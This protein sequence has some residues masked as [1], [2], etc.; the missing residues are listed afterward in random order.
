MQ[1]CETLGI[2]STRELLARTTATELMQWEAYKSLEAEE[3]LDAMGEGKGKMKS[4]NPDQL[5]Q[6]FRANTIKAGGKVN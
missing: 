6:M 2:P 1:L 4:S 3:A 5:F